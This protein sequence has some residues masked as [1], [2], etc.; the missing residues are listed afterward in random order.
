MKLKSQIL[1]IGSVYVSRLFRIS[2]T[3]FVNAFVVRYLGTSQLGRFRFIIEVGALLLPLV[4]FSQ[5]EVLGK[6]LLKEGCKP[7]FMGTSLCVQII[8]AVLIILMLIFFSIINNFENSLDLIIY[9]F[10]FIFYAFQVPGICL[11]ANLRSYEISFSTSI[12]FMLSAIAKL[13]VVYYDLGFYPLVASVIFE[14][15]LLSMFNFYFFKKNN[16]KINFE[17]SAGDILQVYKD[18]FAPFLI[19]ILVVAENSLPM[20]L[21]SNQISKVEFSFLSL[22]NS[23]I[24]MVVFFPQML[25]VFAFPEL[26]RD[27]FNLKQN[28]IKLLSMLFF[29]SSLFILM[30]FLFSNQLFNLL[31]GDQFEKAGFYFKFLSFSTIVYFSRNAILKILIIQQTFGQYLFLIFA[32]VVVFAFIILTCKI[33]ALQ[34][35]LLKSVFPLLMLL[36]FFAINKFFRNIFLTKK[37]IL[38]P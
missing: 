19:S 28:V 8:N 27:E 2:I 34:F 4:T 12:S 32:E 30:S 23:L 33:T 7:E 36:L 26:V 21:I 5:D 25:T 17:F 24:V 14:Y 10:V 37:G 9:S 20:I 1:G 18:S 35:A 16:W 3:V 31:Y 38:K 29:V 22:A 15:A 13:L 6:K 11:S